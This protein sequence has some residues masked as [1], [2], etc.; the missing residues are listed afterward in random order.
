MMMAIMRTM[1]IILEIEMMLML[2]QSIIL[3]EN[4]SRGKSSVISNERSMQ[5]PK[6]FTRKIQY[7]MN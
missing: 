5:P 3:M 2:T 6:S 4:D 7:C 1:V